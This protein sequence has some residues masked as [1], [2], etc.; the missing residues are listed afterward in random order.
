MP[1]KRIDSF[2]E[3]IETAGNCSTARL[4]KHD[5]TAQRLTRCSP[6][7][8]DRRTF[9]TVR[10]MGLVERHAESD[11]TPA[12]MANCSILR[13]YFPFWPG[14]A[15]TLPQLCVLDSGPDEIKQ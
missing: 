1:L 3:P 15:R 7:L 6:V 14:L 4:R 10:E 8:A 12:L 11:S 13:L 5:R 2:A 9:A